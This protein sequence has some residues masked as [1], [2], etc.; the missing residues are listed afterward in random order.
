MPWYGFVHGYSWPILVAALLFLWANGLSI[1][2]GYHRLWSHKAY[3]AHPALGLF[4]ALFG[5]AALQ[6][7]IL[8]WS[9]G[10]RRHHRYVDDND[11]APYCARRGLWFSHIGWMLR[12]YPSGKVDLDNVKDLQRDPIVAWQHKHYVK[13]VLAMNFLPPLLVGLL[14]GD[15]LGSLLVVGV[16]RLVINHHSTFFI[17]SL[18]HYCGK[19]PYTDENTA[20]DSGAM[21][22]LTYGEGYHNFHHLFQSDYRNGIRWWQY[23]PTKWLIKATSW[24]GLSSELNKIPSFKINRAILAM[25]F[26]QAHA[27]LE[28]A[29]NRED[30]RGYLEGEYQQFLSSLNEWSELRQQW[31]QQKR[32]RL[33]EAT[34]ELS[35]ELHRKW[36]QTATH[37]RF[38][39]LDYGLK[40]QL[41]RLDYLT[42]Q[43]A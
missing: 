36:A 12:E 40:M 27:R 5:A 1:T 10:H 13:I 17:N 29:S 8:T 11:K 7:S 6:N 32:E 38:Q 25:K 33:S 34:Q 16:L 28:K 37:S 41:K 9:S 24:I 18:A 20:C 35:Q 3:R 2:A 30:I 15:I 39:E 43:M 19:Q 42:L 26:K 4:F 22:L 21:A 23:D 31:Y 14:F